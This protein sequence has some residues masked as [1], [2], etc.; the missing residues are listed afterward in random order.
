ML[1]GEAEI[2]IFERHLPE[3]HEELAAFVGAERLE[4]IERAATLHHIDEA[5]TEHLAFVAEVREGIHLVGIGGLDPLHEFHKQVAV[6]FSRLHQTVE[7]RTAESL[8]ALEVTGEGELD[9][10]L[11]GPSSTWTY[12]V[13]DRVL[14]ELQQMLFGHGSSAFAAGAAL[15]TWPLLLVWG[16]YRRVSDRWNDSS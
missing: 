15:M 3:R 5:W 16:L 4:E 14:T 1:T 9:L 10:N 8:G 11:R 13:N 7:Q 6:A 12:L 2:R